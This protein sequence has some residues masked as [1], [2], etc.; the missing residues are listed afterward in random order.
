MVNWATP[1]KD[2]PRD[3]ELRANQLLDETKSIESRQSAWHDL[4]LWNAT[5]Y[6]NR[7]LIGFR[8]GDF[9]GEKELWPTN[10][11]TEN[12]IEEIGEAMLSKACSSPL[13][14]TMV[15][16]GNSWKTERAVRLAD[17]FLFSTWRQA[18]AEDKCTQAFRDT[19]TS[20]LG[21]VKV[22]YD[23]DCKEV[24]VESI[25]FDNIII[26]NRECANRAEPRTYRI[27]QVV[28]QESIEATYGVQ[29]GNVDK[30]NATYNPP[31]NGGQRRIGSG[32]VPIV[33]AWRKP[34]RN[35]NGGRHMIATWN[36][37]LVDEPWTDN[38]V[39]LVFFH[40]QDRTDGFFCRSG[41]E[42]LVPYQ[43]KQNDLNEAIT[44]SQD[45]ACRARLLVNANS[46]ID[47]GQWDNEAA[48]ILAYTGQKP[49]PMEW[50]TNLG[51]LY[52]ERERNLAQ[53]KSH[54][55]MSEMFANADIPEQ[56]RLDSSAGVREFRNMEDARHLRLWTK[57]EDGRLQVA[58]LIMR[59]LAKHPKAKAYKSYYYPAGAR[60][61]K[62]I[63]YDAIK[64][65][66][67]DSYSW[68][69]EATP[70]SESSPA[71][72]RE[73]V[74]D[75]TSRGL[76]DQESAKQFL[77]NPNLEMQEQLALAEKDDIS[78]VIALMEEGDYESPNDYTNYN[79]ALVMVKQNYHRL[80]CYDD[81]GP[82]D[83]VVQFHEEYMTELLGLMEAAQPPQPAMT[84]FAPTQ[85]MAGT[86]SASVP[87]SSPSQG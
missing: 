61:A 43:A 65:L 33:E 68:T 5:L 32:Y 75:W 49:E 11:R 73:I 87:V 85:G 50:P 4:N 62:P 38:W 19:F 45:A 79:L 55:A 15:P 51:E 14:P 39:P 27:R 84:P 60:R 13:K 16:H 56:V 66:G 37:I 29:L 54:V 21:C 36:K 82:N 3:E 63:M 47:I 59:V 42:Q 34:D 41:V 57:Y 2:N 78:R 24:C 20:G 25:F 12:I 86:N 26:D 81:V 67:E 64:T 6:T 71:A 70:L 80:K 1:D 9:Q 17:N 22:S 30:Q 74:R 7:Q 28:P 48:R 76:M 44:Q 69:L 18:K 8:W 52:Q 35:G 10:L 46:Q 23:G 83:P 72:R 77:T 53:A 31:V 58:K 40:W